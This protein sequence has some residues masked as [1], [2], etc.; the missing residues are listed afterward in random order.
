MAAQACCVAH[1]GGAWLQMVENNWRWVT[2]RSGLFR[3]S[4]LVVE[5]CRESTLA[6]WKRGLISKLL[7][8][9]EYRSLVR[10]SDRRTA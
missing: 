6:F 5:N 9:P 3:V 2:P 10:L 4:A 1:G 7:S 8:L